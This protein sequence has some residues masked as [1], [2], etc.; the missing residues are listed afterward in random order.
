MRPI[1]SRH[2]TYANVM[3]TVAVFVALGGVAY[4][5]GYVGS[6]GSI[7]GCVRPGGAL[8]VVKPT[9]HCA[10]GLTS[11]TWSQTG[12]RG[13]R[14]RRGVRGPRGPQGQQGVEGQQ[15][16]GATSFNI[17]VELGDNH[18]L[19]YS[20]GVGVG[21]G[22]TASYVEVY[23]VAAPDTVS[24]SGTQAADGN[25]Q[26][27]QTSSGGGVGPIGTNTVNMDVIGMANG[28][29]QRFDL[30]GY[31]DGKACNIWGVVMPATD[32]PNIQ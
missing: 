5:S 26:S 27:I 18:V 9:G 7:H 8:T 21:F 4:A 25:L 20:E 17:H 1:L 22:C 11:L 14:G 28:T 31:T 12:P 19:F 13:R 30:G 32:D 24:V 15:G 16:P 10:S 3:A 2:L 23:L 29:W 6:D